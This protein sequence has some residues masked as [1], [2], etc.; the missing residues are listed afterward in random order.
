MGGTGMG[1]LQ[2][3]HPLVTCMHSFEARYTSEIHQACFWKY[4]NI[5]T[6]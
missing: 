5:N 3:H 1:E 4:A 2:Q 6:N